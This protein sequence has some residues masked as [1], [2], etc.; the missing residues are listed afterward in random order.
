MFADLSTAMPEGSKLDGPGI[1]SA[2][3]IVPL[4]LNGPVYS[5]TLEFPGD[6][7][8]KFPEGSNASAFAPLVPESTNVYCCTELDLS[9]SLKT[10]TSPGLPPYLPLKLSTQ[11]RPDEST[12]SPLV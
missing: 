10:A 8:H 3:E 2:G 6:V 7:T 11:R 9:G 5:K 1:V 4:L 12:P